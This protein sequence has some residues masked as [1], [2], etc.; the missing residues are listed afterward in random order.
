[1]IKGVTDLLSQQAKSIILE[2]CTLFIIRNL[3]TYIHYKFNPLVVNLNAPQ[4][5]HLLSKVR[6]W[7]FSLWVTIIWY[8]SGCKT[9]IKIYGRVTDVVTQINMKLSGM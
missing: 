5:P 3:W 1:V 4:T 7:A 6:D 8:G 9:G 2:T